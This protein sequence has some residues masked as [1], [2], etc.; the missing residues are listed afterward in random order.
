MDS[1]ECKTNWKNKLQVWL[2]KRA[3][4][5]DP[6]KKSENKSSYGIR[7]WNQGPGE[8]SRLCIHMLFVGV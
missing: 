8:N 2:M 6:K 4:V 3:D 5:F 7:G 1:M